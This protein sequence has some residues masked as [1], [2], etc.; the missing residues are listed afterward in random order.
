[1]IKKLSNVV[2]SVSLVVLLGV[3]WSKD[4]FL[5]SHADASSAIYIS[6]AGYELS[7][8]GDSY[9]LDYG[10][11]VRLGE[12][13]GSDEFKYVGADIFRGSSV[14]KYASFTEE[15]LTRSQH[16]KIQEDQISCL[17]SG[18]KDL[19]IIGFKKRFEELLNNFTNNYLLLVNSLGP[20]VVDGDNSLVMIKKIAEKNQL[21][22]KM[23][24]S[25]IFLMPD[26]RSID[27][28]KLYKL[29]PRADNYKIP[30]ISRSADDWRIQIATNL[31]YSFLLIF[32][33]I[34]INHKYL[35]RSISSRIKLDD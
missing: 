2:V 10:G 11:L 28:E 8:K 30:I 23:Q 17:N 14:I 26:L 7:F 35:F 29:R 16:L 21:A 18:V 27:L 12:Q 6:Y 22:E 1:M 32:L 19:L 4:I 20:Q 33:L 31:I 24:R 13:C 15:P 34:G 25:K 5:K 9:A 3:L